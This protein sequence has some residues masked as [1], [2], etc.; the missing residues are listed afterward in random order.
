[1]LTIGVD[2]GLFKDAE[3]GL[4]TALIGLSV[5]TLCFERAQEALHHR[6]LTSGRPCRSMSL[7]LTGIR[8]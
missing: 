3:F 2:E 8:N 1:M 4:R 7:V 5:H 6:G